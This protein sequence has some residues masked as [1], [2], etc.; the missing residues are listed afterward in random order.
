MLVKGCCAGLRTGR[1]L[2]WETPAGSTGPVPPG[3]GAPLGPGQHRR[4]DHGLGLAE[5]HRLTRAR[6]ARTLAGPGA[7]GQV[8][9]E[10]LRPHPH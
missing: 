10:K 9:E 7:R 5:V 2:P 6:H 3:P 8:G 1:Q 4:Q